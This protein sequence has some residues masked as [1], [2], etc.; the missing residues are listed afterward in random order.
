MSETNRQLL[1]IGLFFITI[2]V[3]LLLFATGV[4][5]W[6]LIIPV[7]LLLSGSGLIALGILRANRPTKFERSP[8]ST[9]AMGIVVFAAGGAWILFGISWIYSLIVI[10]LALAAIA[11][12]AALRH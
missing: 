7:I 4:I 6:T 11:I 9:A 1:G 5:D 2:V 3:A 12:A 8:F 10:L